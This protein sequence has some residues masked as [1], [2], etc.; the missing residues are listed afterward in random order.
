MSKALLEELQVREDHWRDACCRW[1][2]LVNVN[3]V[4]QSLRYKHALMTAR[5]LCVTCL[6]RIKP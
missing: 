4:P 3:V 5:L 2:M 1:S 6:Q